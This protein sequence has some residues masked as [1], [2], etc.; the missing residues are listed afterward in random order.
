MIRRPPRST[1]TDTLFP[2]TTLF[3]SFLKNPVEIEVAARN[4]T[5]D[6]VTQIAYPLAGNEKRAAVVHLVKSR[7][8]NQVIVFSNTKISTGRLAC[9]LVRDG[10]KAESI[11]GDQRQM[12]RMKELDD[13]TNGEHEVLRSEERRGGKEG[14]SQY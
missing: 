13:L 6:T 3:R 1:R 14:F 5:A 11:H 7:G 10:V 4:A 2:Y 9:E 8:F 12:D